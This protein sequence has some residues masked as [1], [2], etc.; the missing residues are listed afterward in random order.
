MKG[1]PLQSY[2]TLEDFLGSLQL[3][4][5]LIVLSC[6]MPFAITLWNFRTTPIAL[7]QWS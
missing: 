1:L 6:P 2:E 4:R 7:L 5:F 3:S